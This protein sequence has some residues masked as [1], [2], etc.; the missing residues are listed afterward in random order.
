MKL[1]LLLLFIPLS[2]ANTVSSVFLANNPIP[3]ALKDQ[4]LREV[5]A[6]CAR[7]VMREGLKEIDTKLAVKTV[8]AQDNFYTTTFATRYY[9]E[10]VNP[11]TAII[12][13]V[14]ADYDVNNTVIDR[15]EIKNIEAD[16]DGLCK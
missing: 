13:V 9:F 1:A 4:I 15:Y 16:T 8:G 11:V 10:G 7:G 6:R 3:V 12:T 14:S 5:E 2:L